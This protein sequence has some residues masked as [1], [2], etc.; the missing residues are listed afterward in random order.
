MEPEIIEEQVNN[1]PLDENALM[2]EIVIPNAEDNQ[3]QQ[4]DQGQNQQK[5]KDDNQRAAGDDKG[6]NTQTVDEYW[7]ELQETFGTDFQIPEAIVKGVNE[8]GEKLTKK[9]KFSMLRNVM[10]DTTQF[11]NSPDDDAFV[12]QY[13]QASTQEGFNRK[14]FLSRQNQ[15]AN[16][17]DMPAREFMFMMHKEEV[18]KTD[19]NPDGLTDE[20]INELLDKKTSAELKMESMQRKK[21]I[22]DYYAQQEEIHAKANEKL[23]LEEFTKVEEENS[24]LVNTYIDKIKN[25]SNIEGIEFSEADKAQFQKDLPDFMKR[26]IKEVNGKKIAISKAEMLLQDITSDNE[27]SMSLMPILWMVANNK[28]KGYSSTLKEQVKKGLEDKFDSFRRIERGQG[29]NTTTEIDANALMA[30]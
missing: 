26:E 11:G 30:D 17:L 20:D 2:D 21:G 6:D 9:E 14:E 23:F 10:L 5:A 4:Q 12:R 29:N 13:L 7:E 18:G 8:K 16:I 24:K 28:F 25:T 1:E 3:Q 19:E 15:Q 22:R 27:K